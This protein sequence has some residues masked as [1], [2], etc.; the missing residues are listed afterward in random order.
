VR[1]VD[2]GAE[3]LLAR[4]GGAGAAG[5]EAELVVEA[6]GDLVGGEEANLGGGELDGEGDAVEAPGDLGDG[7]GVVG[8]DGEGWV[9]GL[10]AVEE[11]ADGLELGELV[12]R[13]EVVGVGKGEGGDA[14]GD[15]AGDAEGLAG[16]SEDVEVRAGEEEGV[17]EASGGV[18]EV[19]AVVEDEEEVF[20]LEEE[21]EGVFGEEARLLAEVECLGDG[22]GDEVGVGE[23]SELGEEDAVLEGVEEVGGDLEGEASFAGAAD[24]GEGDEAVGGEEGFDEGDLALAADEGGELEG[25][26]VG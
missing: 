10:S 18:D 6:A 22:V 13:R 19:F 9:D 1:P 14:E 5:E 20:S 2:C 25:E 4:D 26:V 24:G 17:G 11:E 12:G 21:D 16:G 15:F 23:L 8:G 3:G 7:G